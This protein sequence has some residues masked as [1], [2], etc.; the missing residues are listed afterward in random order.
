MSCKNYEEEIFESF[1]TIDISNDLQSHLKSCKACNEI[2]TNLHALSTGI[3]SD[4]LFYDSENAIEKRVD[5]INTKIDEIELSKV[6][7]PARWKS[8]V[9]MAAAIF[10]V[11][12]IGLIS[13]LVLYNNDTNL[14]AD[15]S[16]NETT[17]V[18]LNA[19]ETKAL[20]EIEISEFVDQYS[21]EYR[22]DN[23]LSLL[24]DISEEEYQYLEEN[25][26]IGEI[27]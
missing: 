25:L 4:D 20:S 27:L 19:T 9:P 2:Y 23:E 21:S 22:L 11:L 16:Q 3:G 18:S 7:S 14:V 24:D 13:K 26:K 10:L 15:L 8:Y 12:G 1:G 17:L 6:I 5:E